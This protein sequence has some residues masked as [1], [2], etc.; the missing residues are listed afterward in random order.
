MV[1]MEKIS[2][3]GQR[4]SMGKGTA[5]RVVLADDHDVVRQGLKRLLDRAAGIEVVGEARNGL[6]AL[7]AVRDLHPDVLLLD[8]EMPVMDGVE[9]ARRLRASNATVR[10]LVLSAYDDQEY[11]RA[12][13]DIGVWGYLVK[14]EA[15]G[16]IV[17]AVRGV[18][19]GQKGWVSQQVRKKLERMKD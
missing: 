14:G 5:T 19:E 17:E 9:V 3:E 11:I 18:A 12:L 2:L 15:P 6:E 4:I 7:K 13:Q 8:I 1:A 16:K 10:I